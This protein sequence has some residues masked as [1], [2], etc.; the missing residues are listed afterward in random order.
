MS[1]VKIG[2]GLVIAVLIALAVNS[3]RT[4]IVEPDITLPTV[5]VEDIPTEEPTP[6]STLVPSTSVVVVPREPKER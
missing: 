5:A 3:A 4:P 2:I 6:E 1:K